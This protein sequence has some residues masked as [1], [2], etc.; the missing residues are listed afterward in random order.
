M[1]QIHVCMGILGPLVG[2][3]PSGP[4]EWGY[5]GLKAMVPTMIYY[6]FDVENELTFKSIVVE[7]F[8][9]NNF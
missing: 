8:K 3:D 9:S 7:I 4:S 6:L 1:V 2:I 5:L